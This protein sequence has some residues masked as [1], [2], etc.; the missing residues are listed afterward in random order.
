MFVSKIIKI[1]DSSK[2]KRKPIILLR[3]DGSKQKGMGDLVSLMNISEY[4]IDEYEFSRSGAS[5]DYTAY[6]D[7]GLGDVDDVP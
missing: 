2:V 1:V 7:H 3:A 6:D 5:G 4:L